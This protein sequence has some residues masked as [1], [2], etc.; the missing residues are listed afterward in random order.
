[1]KKRRVTIHDIAKEL[2][3]TASTVSRALQDHPRISKATKQAILE[4]AQKLDYQPNAMASSLRKGKGNTIGVIIPRIDRYFFSSVIRG[5][6]DVAYEAGYNVIISQSYDSK[7]REKEIVETLINGKVDGLLVSISFETKSYEHFQSIIS[8]GIPLIFFDRVP[9]MEIS[10]VEL[11]DFA[12]GFKAVEHLINQGC[13]NIVHLAGYKHISIY[14]NRYEGYKAAL[15]RYNMP[16][17]DSFVFE[18]A[19]TKERGEEVAHKILSMNPRPDGIFCAGDYSAM[20]VMLKLKELG[21]RI[22]KDIAIVGFA[23]EPYA[24]ITSPSL[25]S[26]DQHS[27]EM[28]QSV[29]RLFLEQIAGTEAVLPKR[30]ILSPDLFI[31]QSS[32]RKQ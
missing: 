12:G 29:A 28:G 4:L 27:K 10:K 16:F 18:N 20:G 17:N 19:V 6:E 9:D 30:I 25:S 32:Q 5:I 2:N 1:M 22:P 23:N 3:T 31:R 13:T 26:V 14:R 11:D 24:E 21:I 7:Q 15:I 8:R